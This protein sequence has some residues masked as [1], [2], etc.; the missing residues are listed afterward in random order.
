MND[1]SFDI[2][3]LCV[4]E[5][6]WFDSINNGLEF[7][8]EPISHVILYNNG[9]GY[10]NVLNPDESLPLY[11]R[12]PSATSRSGREYYI[13]S[14]VN[15]VSGET[16]AG[17]AWLL[18]DIDLSKSFSSASS[19]SLP[20]IENY[21]INSPLFFHDRKPFLESMLKDKNNGASFIERMRWKRLIDSDTSKLARMHSFFE[22]N[23]LQIVK[24]RN[25]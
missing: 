12:E 18:T 9:D 25:W 5:V 2:G 10:F 17:P 4:A 21:V 24:N 13:G 22:G 6:K 1:V 7:T 20:E 16:V 8:T 3:K 11:K 23:G 14:A 19:V 15:L